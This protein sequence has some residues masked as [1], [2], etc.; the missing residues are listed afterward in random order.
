MRQIFVE[1]NMYDMKNLYYCI[2]TVFFITIVIWASNNTN[3]KNAKYRKKRVKYTI[4]LF[5]L[6]ILL[7]RC[8]FGIARVLR[9]GVYGGKW[10]N[11]QV[12]EARIAGCTV[13]T[14][15]ASSEIA[16]NHFTWSKNPTVHFNGR[17]SRKY[18]CKIVSFQWIFLAFFVTVAVCC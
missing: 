3:S 10:Q 16:I 2:V 13:K 1:K 15:S 12:I 11:F 17:L 4:N 14:L 7:L 6:H 18:A 5:A 8:I 9:D